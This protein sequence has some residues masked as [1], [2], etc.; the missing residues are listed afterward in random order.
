MDYVKSIYFIIVCLWLD[1][2]NKYS[3]KYYFKIM[4]SDGYKWYD[5]VEKSTVL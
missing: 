3:D 2:L 5:C 4:T 1:S